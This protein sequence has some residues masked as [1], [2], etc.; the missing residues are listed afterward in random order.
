MHLTE[1]RT[2]GVLAH[3]SCLPGTQR[4]GA[5][6]QDTVRFLDFL[7]ASGFSLWQILPLGPVDQTGSPY[8]SPSAF[9]GDAR[10]ICHQE[11]IALGLAPPTPLFP[12]PYRNQM[13]LLSAYDQYRNVHEHPFQQRVIQFCAEQAHWVYDYALFCAIKSTEEGRAWSNWPAALRDRDAEALAAFRHQHQW[14][15]D[16]FLFE[17]CVFFAQWQHIRQQ[18]HQRQIRI[19]G[20]IPIFVAWDSA[21]VWANR[22]LFLLDEQ[23][24]PKC[25]AG[26]PPDYFSPEGQ[27][28]GNPL[29][30]WTQ[31]S[32]SGFAWWI[33]RIGHALKL[34]D[35]VRIDHFRGFSACWEIPAAAATAREGRWVEVPGQALFDALQQHFGHLPIIA[36]DLG[37]IT[38]DVIALRDAFKLPGMSILQFAFDGSPKNPYLPHNLQRNTVVYTGTHDNNTTLGWYGELTSEEK[39]RVNHYFG[40]SSEPMPRPLLRAALA[41]VAH[42]A[43]LPLQDLLEMD[44]AARMNTPGTETDNWQWRCQWPDFKEELAEHCR[45]LLSSYGR[46]PER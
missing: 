7:Q 5:L 43:I 30:E 16:Y 37:I 23:G 35:L 41:S 42:T 13:P 17:Q 29:Y 28:W 46:I 2:A 10:L 32:A 26:V 9:A 33:A 4:V 25:V 20:D 40:F 38:D 45:Y 15:V 22:E 1:S 3:P 14:L 27:H 19:L 34:F 24:L 8:N 39:F 36:E 31:L 44:A 6:G 12:D 11:M 21:D 18:A